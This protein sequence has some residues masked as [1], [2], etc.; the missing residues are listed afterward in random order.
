MLA[1]LRVEKL[2]RFLEETK[3][4]QADFMARRLD[5]IVWEDAHIKKQFQ[6]VAAYE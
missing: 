3:S 4:L 2:R 1:D 5:A 6:R